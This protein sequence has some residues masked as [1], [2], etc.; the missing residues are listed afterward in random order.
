MKNA[1]AGPW[2]TGAAQGTRRSAIQLALSASGGR[3]GCSTRRSL[4]HRAQHRRVVHARIARGIQQCHALPPGALAQCLQQQS[5]SAQLCAVAAGEFRPAFQVTVKPGAQRR[6]RCELR[7]PGIETSALLADTARPEPIDEHPIAIVTRGGVVD[8]LDTYAVCRSA[9]TSTP[10]PARA[11]VGVPGPARLER[12]PWL[13]SGPGPRTLGS[14][15]D[16]TVTHGFAHESR[17]A[18]APPALA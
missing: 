16:T 18:G 5:L 9:A 2:L 7:E 3:P 15:C 13:R 8:A 11:P 12:P 4:Q 6:T 1:H 17:A 10:G 14:M